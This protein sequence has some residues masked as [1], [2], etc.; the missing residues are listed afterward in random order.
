MFYLPF[1][2]RDVDPVPDCT[3][4]LQW[5]VHLIRLARDLL[6]TSELLTAKGED[7]GAHLS[8]PTM[9]GAYA[10][11]ER[12]IQI[13]WPIPNAPCFTFGLAC[14]I[15]AHHFVRYNMVS[16][17]LGNESKVGSTLARL[18]VCAP[19]RVCQTKYLRPWLSCWRL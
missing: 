11:D 19:F 17:T 7:I 15:M 6:P 16:G 1:L 8:M 12:P 4:A 13:P 2:L 9:C 14:A 5:H 10:W 3:V 18:R